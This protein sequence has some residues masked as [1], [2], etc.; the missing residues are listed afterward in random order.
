MDIALRLRP[1]L[2][3]GYFEK[4]C[5]K[6]LFY[7]ADE[8]N[9]YKRPAWK[10][11]YG[12]DDTA[13]TL[14]G[15]EWENIMLERLQADNSVI[16]IDLK[17]SDD[18]QDSYET[19]VETLRTLQ[20][21]GKPIYLYQ[22]CLKTT[23]SFDERY[24]SQYDAF[25]G[26]VSFGFMFPDFIKAEYRHDINKFE[27]TVIDAKNAALVKAGAEIQI[28][29]YVEIIKYLL[30]DL[31]IDN[32][33][34]NEENGIVWNKEPVTRNLVEHAFGLREALF[35]IDEFFD[36]T[37]LNIVSIVDSCSDQSEIMKKLDY[38]I[39]Q[40][41]EYCDRYEDCR[42]FC[43]KERSAR[44]IPYM[45]KNAQKVLKELIASGTLKDDSIDSVKELLENE[46]E[47][48]TSD[49]NFWRL[50]KNNL[51]AYTE[52]LE[53]LFEDKKGRFAKTGAS[54]SF[55]ATQ[56]FAL[57]LTAQQDVNRGRNYAYAWLLKP[58][59]NIDIWDQGIN[60]NG[61][62]D[63]RERKKESPGKGTYYDSLIA[64]SDS[65]AEF[66]R[67][68][69]EFVESIFELLRRID[70]Y[71]DRKRLQIY[72]MDDYEQ[73]N[74]E[75]ALFNMLDYLDPESDHE[76]ISKTMQILFWMQ[77]PRHVTDL[78]K[79]P[80]DVVEH[81]VT[82]L[83]SEISRL[84]VLS[85]GIAY[86][87]REVASV[88]TDGLYHEHEFYKYD[89]EYLGILTNI[90]E[91]MTI[92]DA[93][94]EKDVSKKQLKIENLG[95]HLRKR[96]FIES[97]IVKTIQNDNKDGIHLSAKP[98]HFEML[99]SIFDEYPEI[100]KLLFENRYE[101]QLSIEQLML[102]RASGIQAAIDKGSILS[103]QYDE[104]EGKFIILNQDTF[105]ARDWYAS[106]LCEDTEE[107]RTQIMLFRDT[108]YAREIMWDAEIPIKNT[109][110]VFYKVQSTEISET[111]TTSYINIRFKESGFINK[112]SFKPAAGK[113]Y[114]F[115]EV[116]LGQNTGK[117]E[118]KLVEL[119]SSLELLD[120]KAMTG[121]TGVIFD[122]AI[123][124]K[125]W[126]PDGNE[127]SDS[128]KKAFK[129]LMERKLTVIE[130]PPASGKT[131]FIARSIITI[132]S[133]YKEKKNRNLRILVSAMSHSAIENMLLKID[134]ML[135]KSEK[136]LGI[137]LF[138]A[139]SYDDSLA[140]SGTKVALIGTDMKVRRRLERHPDEISVLGATCFFAYKL[141]ERTDPR[142]SAILEKVK[143][144]II[145]IDEASQLKAMDAFIALQLGHEDTRYMLVGD[146][147]Q[148]PPI[149]LGKYKRAEDRKYIHG[150][151][152]TMYLTG[153]N[154]DLPA[155]RNHSD[156]VELKDNYRMNG[157]MCRYPSLKLYGEDY[158]AASDAIRDQKIRLKELPEDGLLASILDPDYPLVFC[159]LSGTA[160]DQKKAEISL[161]TDI[162]EALWQN[163][164][165]PETGELASTQGNFWIETD[166]KG[167]HL[168]GSCGIISPHHE[169]I[170]RLRS[171]VSTRLGIPRDNVYIGT[172]DKLQGKERKTVIVSYGVSETEKILNERE[173]IF[174]RN[175][176]NV[177]ITR[178]KAKTIVILS[179][180]L[181]E[182]NLNTNIITAN[183]KNLREGIEFI[184]GF[185]DYMKT[186]SP[187]ENLIS[188]EYPGAL[189]NVNIKLW[190]KRLDQE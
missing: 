99:R 186:E 127:F 169:H 156:V 32:C 101:E 45:T 123:C 125:Y 139:G 66:D 23:P 184:H 78:K 17:Q 88:F 28:A 69:R 151:I 2:I 38:S 112:A 164:L 67:I 97:D 35:L 140:F 12:T 10:R 152:F 173:F 74:V 119:E 86:N 60:E 110:T 87:I 75:N 7:R 29:L 30:A 84:Y 158:K 26:T 54:I 58:G 34:V 182:P 95:R 6:Y 157:I 141:H 49:C 114:L 168:D 183:D 13:A 39:A 171:S 131:D 176:F 93:W 20:D 51:D 25:P 120:P 160:G 40:G 135:K 174:S 92:I 111:G 144:D 46:P 22:A 172:V 81:P 161:V 9:G 89:N 128:Q 118:E 52:G 109:D 180:E 94:K 104:D 19:T 187:G 159:E 79:I 163:Q 175:R 15:K 162:V 82:V 4:E 146:E 130:G 181:A 71:P 62:V 83:T 48:M 106:L 126:S 43:I 138:K 73:R 137:K 132:A 72:V 80:A 57:L 61:F 55:P 149:V 31:G 3:G 122:E 154:E 98:M 124:R 59:W 103:L 56:D 113:K 167:K 91:G 8:K 96:L 47:L 37:L 76:L 1:S 24:L 189:E 100:A 116:Y 77:G 129:N 42:K 50:V 102:S 44:L 115:F 148:L 143:Y 170:N 105:I 188:E 68:D 11:K 185:S 33:V 63:I 179:E 90:I 190:K 134:K 16:L 27:L 5:D 178:G 147:K 36:K 85:E 155:N 142:T 18:N 14:A 121:D 177:S 153:L 70:N 166:Y 64:E 65:E 117:T 53:C 145:I 108:A 133:Y 107:N 165:N 41:C 150:S 136:P 21:Q